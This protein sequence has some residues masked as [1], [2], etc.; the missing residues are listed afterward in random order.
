[1]KPVLNVTLKMAMLQSGKK[2]QRIADLARIHRSQL[3]HIVRGR[4]IATAKERARLARVLG[5]AEADLFTEPGH[6]AETD[7]LSTTAGAV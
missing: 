2:Q 7:E 3:S 4:R 6:A 5:Q 1:M